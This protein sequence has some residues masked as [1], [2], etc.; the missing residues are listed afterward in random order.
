SLAIGQF[1]LVSQGLQMNCQGIKVDRAGLKNGD[2]V[3]LELKTEQIT[4]TQD[5]RTFKV[6]G[7]A[8]AQ[9]LTAAQSELSPLKM[10]HID[11]RLWMEFI[12]QVRDYLSQRSLQEV[13]TPSLVTN[14]G[15][16]P[17]LEPFSTEL[18]VGSKK[19]KLFIPTS[20][21]LHLKQL[22]A[23]DYTDI[24]E[25]KTCL[26]NGEVTQIHQPE[27]QMLE[28]YRAYSNL[29]LIINDLIGLLQSFS[30]EIGAEQAVD[31]SP[32]SFLFEKHLGFKLTPI[33]TR[34]ELI[35]LC[36]TA[37][38]DWSE[39]DSW[40]DLFHRL[41]FE[42]IEPK[43]DPNVPTIV[44]EYPPSQAALARINE[45]GWADRFELYWQGLE[46]ANAFHEL[47]DPVE[48][49]KRFER[50][51]KQ[52]IENGKTPLEIDENFMR[53]LECGMPPSA[54]IALGLDRLFMAIYGIKQIENARL[55]DVSHVLKGRSNSL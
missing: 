37:K 44:I 43:I 35:E 12:H 49:R 2:K 14:P 53:A 45:A 39:T 18:V 27:F 42:R 7:G 54:G 21:E 52:R 3:L 13:T 55:F 33:T 16:E 47:N 36:K 22:L 8:L 4:F 31:V 1:S 50:D 23:H 5:T 38:V 48:Q 9:K 28:W 6:K 40:D 51:Q 24:F 32:I 26:R 15:M 29:S 25:I 41:M 19:Q 46:I 10:D 34:N 17:Q 20:P 11:S 30:P